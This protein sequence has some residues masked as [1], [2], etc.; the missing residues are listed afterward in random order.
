MNFLSLFFIFILASPG[1]SCFEIPLTPSSFL[2]IEILVR[3]YY[4][5]EQWIEWSGLEATFGAEVKIET[6]L[7]TTTDGDEVKAEGVF[8]LNQPDEKN[9]YLGE[10]GKLAKYHVNF[11]TEIFEI[12]ELNCNLKHSFRA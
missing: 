7:K 5:N 1:F 2:Q 8:F 12:A 3:S 4:L 10:K 9:I 6:Y 11:K